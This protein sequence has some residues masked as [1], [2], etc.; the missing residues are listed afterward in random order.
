MTRRVMLVGLVLL[1]PVAMATEAEGSWRSSA[2]P[3]ST[4]APRR[5]H[6]LRRSSSRA[7]ASHRLGPRH[8][9]RFPL[10][11]RSSTSEASS[12]SLG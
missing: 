9:S 3:S 1:A 6:P 2:A 8:E 7:A 4:L 10:A 11:R 5:L 12:S